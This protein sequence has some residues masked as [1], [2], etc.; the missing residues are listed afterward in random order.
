M[1]DINNFK[2][3]KHLEGHFATFNKKKIK[4][5]RIFSWEMGCMALQVKEKLLTLI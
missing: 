3:R 4:L 1:Y 5:S 2:N